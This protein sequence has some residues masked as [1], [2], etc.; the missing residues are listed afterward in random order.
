[1]YKKINHLEVVGYI[2]SYF[3]KC[4]NNRKS[5]FVYLFLFRERAKSWKTSK[6]SII[7]LPTMKAE[8][9]TYFEVTC[10]S[11]IMIVKHYFKT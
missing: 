3:I 4:I 8:F 5:N 11:Y 10:N 6:Q 2:N 9:V 1:M 7:V